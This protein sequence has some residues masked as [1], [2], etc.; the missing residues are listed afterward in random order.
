[1]KTDADLGYMQNEGITEENTLPAKD[2]IYLF[3]PSK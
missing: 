1:M 3:I 2:Y